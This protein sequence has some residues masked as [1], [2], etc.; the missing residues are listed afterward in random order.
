VLVPKS[1]CGACLCSCCLGSF[2]GVCMWLL[3][4]SAQAGSFAVGRTPGHPLLVLLFTCVCIICTRSM[5]VALYELAGLCKGRTLCV[6]VLLRAL[7]P[8][9]TCCR[10]CHGAT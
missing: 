2:G 10:G 6:R 3:V 7:S 4:P 5:C 1:K 8:A 9:N